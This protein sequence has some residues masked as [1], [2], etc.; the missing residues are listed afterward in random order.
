MI[1]QIESLLLIDGC[2]KTSRTNEELIRGTNLVRNVSVYNNAISAMNF[3]GKQIAK[4]KSLPNII[5]IGTKLRKMSSW[6]F[7]EA[8]R[9]HAIDLSKHEIYVI[10]NDGNTTELIQNSLHPLTEAIINTPL[11]E[12]EIKGILSKYANRLNMGV[13]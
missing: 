1:T 7:L 4:G 3:I 9:S 10:N 8:L 13:A 5:L 6:D 2:V 12:W 11:I